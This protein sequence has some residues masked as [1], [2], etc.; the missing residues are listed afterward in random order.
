MP[1]LTSLANVKSYLAITTA[2]SDALISA[3][4]PRASQHVERW[5]GRSLPLVS[6]SG[7]RLS[8]YGG[9]VLVLPD[10]PIISVS[11]VSVDGTPVVESSDGI[12]VAGYTYEAGGTSISLVGS[13]FPR[14]RLNV[15]VSWVA[16]YRASE[17]ANV[18]ASNTPTLTPTEGGFASTNVS[19][20]DASG[21]NLTQVTGTPL[22]DQYSF[23]AGVYTFNTSNAN[24]PVTMTYGYAPGP[25]EQAV[26]EMIGLDLKQR[27][28][29]GISSKGL[30]GENVTYTDKGMTASVR[31][32]L[33]PYR[34]MVPL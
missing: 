32:M 33:W 6:Q 31:E 27:D 21:A 10:S 14:G 16:G 25:I 9:P 8:G 23:A 3:L 11:A 30:A 15:A 24:D 20:A 1:N 4:I 28:N 7:K 12:L 5:L 22:A 26:I 2:G 17:T 13:V 34:K 19:V 29:L 18:P